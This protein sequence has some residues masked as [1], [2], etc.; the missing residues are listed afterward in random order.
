MI[1]YKTKPI[2]FNFCYEDLEKRFY[3]CK[4]TAIKKQYQHKNV[5]LKLIDYS[6][7]LM[8]KKGYSE[9]LYHFSNDRTK[10]LNA[11]YRRNIIKQKYYAILKREND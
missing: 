9:V 8:T 10:V 4:T 7:N 6:Y 3:V 5:L 2:A 1:Y 11:I